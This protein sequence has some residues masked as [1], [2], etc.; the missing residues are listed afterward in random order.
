M[1][2]NAVA[3]GSDQGRCHGAGDN[4]ADGGLEMKSSFVSCRLCSFREENL[5]RIYTTI[6]DADHHKSTLEQ[7]EE[8][9]VF[10][11]DVSLGITGLRFSVRSK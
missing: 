1:N 3:A 5:E 10:F 4:G 7:R 2:S 8:K 9:R 6:R 11:C